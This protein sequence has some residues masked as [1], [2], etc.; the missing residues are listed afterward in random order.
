MTSSYNPIVGTDTASTLI[1][2]TVP[3]LSQPFPVMTLFWALPL[4]DIVDL[5]A[6]ND[7]LNFTVDAWRQGLRQGQRLT[8]S[9]RFSTMSGGAGN[10]TVY[11][12]KGSGFVAY[13]DLGSDTLRFAGN[14]S[15]SSIYGGN[16]SDATS[17]DGAD[18]IHVSGTLSSAL[19][20]GN[21]GNDLFYINSSVVGGS[22]V[23]GGQGV[24]SIDVRESLSF[25]RFR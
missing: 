10:D 2:S 16:T 5:G 14:L 13:G 6:G 20:H 4:F 23:Y 24:D 11:L 9:L 18:S 1:S 22:S 3:T 21:G 12:T 25:H 19:L 15:S 17:A 7:S 8:P